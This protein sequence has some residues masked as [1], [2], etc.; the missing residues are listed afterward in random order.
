[1]QSLAGGQGFCNRRPFKSEKKLQGDGIMKLKVNR[2]I[3]SFVAIAAL[4]ILALPLTV[5]AVQGGQV[6]RYT[7]SPFLTTG[8]CCTTVKESVAVTEPASVVPVVVDFNTDYQ[9]DV[10]GN[11]GLVVNGGSCNLFLGPNRL[12]A[13]T[14]GTDGFGDFGNIHYRWVVKPADGVLKTGKNTFA[15]CIGGSQGN[16]ANIELGFNTLT[17]QISN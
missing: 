2:K 6:F 1:M 10:E 7:G 13:F 17:V 4:A 5:F 8:V 3:T 12:P 14:L 9:S 16:T 15:P 11:V